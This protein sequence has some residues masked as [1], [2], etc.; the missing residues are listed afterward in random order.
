[1]VGR[2]DARVTSMH[3]DGSRRSLFQEGT[4]FQTFRNSLS[5]SKERE[6]RPSRKCIVRV[7]TGVHTP[8]LDLMEKHFKS[9]KGA[10]RKCKHLEIVFCIPLATALLLL[11]GS[12]GALEFAPLSLDIDDNIIRGKRGKQ[13]E[14]SC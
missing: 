13:R 12:L 2:N 14:N 7:V 1:M 10:C 5:I 8:F 3:S 6:Q 11:P 4:T 9:Q